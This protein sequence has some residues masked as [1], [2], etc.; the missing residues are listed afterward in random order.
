MPQSIYDNGGMIGAALDFTDTSR[1]LL[2]ET[3]LDIE[4]ISSTGVQTFSSPSP[5]TTIAI[6]NSELLV[7]GDIVLVFIASD[8]GSTF[9]VLTL[10]DGYRTG[11][12]AID[13]SSATMNTFWGYKFMGPTPDTEVVFQATNYAETYAIA[14][15]RGVED[16]DTIS[17]RPATRTTA[18]SGSLTTPE[19]VGTMPAGSLIL[20][21]GYL[22]DDNVAS[23][24]SAPSGYTLTTATQSDATGATMMVAHK[25]TS[26]AQTNEPAQT[27]TTSGSDLWY[28]DSVVLNRGADR[29]YGNQKNSGIW[30]LRT[31]VPELVP[32]SY[33]FIGSFE[34][35]DSTN[36]FFGGIDIGQPGLVIVTYHSEQSAIGDV[37]INGSPASIAI[38]GNTF[39]NATVAVHYKEVL[40]TNIIS[41]EAPASTRRSTV[42]VW[43]ANGYTSAVPQLTYTDAFVTGGNY[44][45]TTD[46]LA[47]QSII[48]AGMSDEVGIS[49]IV[50][51]TWTNIGEDYDTNTS[52][53]GSLFTGASLIS[54]AGL[55]LTLDVVVDQPELSNTG[56]IAVAV[57]Q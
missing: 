17:I 39:P 47:K 19:L 54:P 31:T 9:G 51:A 29:V 22:D 21:M 44:S 15:F 23:S 1:Y 49:G 43:R 12:V 57:W 13:S 36:A 25:I 27:F 8:A 52:E 34:N 40:D 2:S 28:A 48:I 24:V 53:G 45:I 42:G 10:P 50:S 33:E 3:P 56:R 26:S 55:G 7:E 4:L 35:I 14:V 11:R 30:S 41:I 37:L 32:M 46:T 6:P 20:Q 16:I 38:E 18:T 5:S